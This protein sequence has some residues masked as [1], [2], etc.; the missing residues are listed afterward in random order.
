MRGLE[1]KGEGG[2]GLKHSQEPLVDPFYLHAFHRKFIS[3]LQPLQ[4]VSSDANRLADINAGWPRR[5]K[6]LQC[7]N[8]QSGWQVVLLFLKL[9][10]ISYTGSG[11][12]KFKGSSGNH[13]E[14]QQGSI[15]MISVHVIGLFSKI[16]QLCLK[17]GPFFSLMS[18]KGQIW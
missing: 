1:E 9:Q 18:V 2:A 15:D 4:G 8:S 17:Q 3:F 16:R 13:M 10:P 11:E 12:G 7:D 14:H 6:E 5:K